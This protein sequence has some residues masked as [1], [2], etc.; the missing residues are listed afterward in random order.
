MTGTT[1]FKAQALCCLSCYYY[2]QDP[3]MRPLG[4]PVSHWKPL[5]RYVLESRISWV[6]EE[7]LILYYL[8]TPAG[9]GLVFRAFGI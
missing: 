5:A 9:S 8:K 1:G 3:G 4:T 6:L 2:F 7:C